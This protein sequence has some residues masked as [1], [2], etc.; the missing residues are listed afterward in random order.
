M[1]FWIALGNGEKITWFGGIEFSQKSEVLWNSQGIWIPDLHGL[2]F[3]V[4]HLSNNLWDICQVW[5]LSSKFWGLN[6]D[7]SAKPQKYVKGNP[8]ICSTECQCLWSRK[9]KILRSSHNCQ[10]IFLYVSLE[11][12]GLEWLNGKR[13]TSVLPIFLYIRYLRIVLDF[14]LIHQPCI[15]SN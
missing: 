8:T 9:K 4:L 6:K 11:L 2:V 5:H 15:S 7:I 14:S 12:S 10:G 13:S 1:K 3:L